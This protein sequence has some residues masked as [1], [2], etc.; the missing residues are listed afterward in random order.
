MLKN[1]IT[2]CSI[3]L[4]SNTVFSQECP[5]NSHFELEKWNT[6]ANEHFATIAKDILNQYEQ[7]KE[8]YVP[9][10]EALFFSE[11]LQTV[12]LIKSYD[13]IRTPQDKMFGDLVIMT[14]PVTD[15]L[16]EIRWYD[17]KTKHIIYDKQIRNC[18]T[19]VIPN[20]VNS[21]F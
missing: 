11:E 2:L 6:H 21:L 16:A 10:I 12:V 14:L 17:G 1:V 18:A 3:L 13:D 9:D 7:N 20:A 15:E 8:H 5:L 19:E 4:F